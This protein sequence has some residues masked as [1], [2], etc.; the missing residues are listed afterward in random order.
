VYTLGVQYSV[1]AHT[2]GEA[3]VK[4]VRKLQYVR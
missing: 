3:L 4:T 1:H 2:G